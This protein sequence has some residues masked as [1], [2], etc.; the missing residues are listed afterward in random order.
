MSSK[1]IWVILFALAMGYLESAVVVYLRALYYPEGFN[2]PLKEMSETLALTELFREAATLIMIFSV[3]VLVAKYWLHRFAW[4]LMVFAVWDISYYVFLK[5][6]LGW[7]ESL[8]TNDI[9]FLLPGIW[10]GPVIAP[11]INSIS[12]IM[13]AF[14]ILKSSESSKPVFQLSLIVWVLLITGSLLILIAYMEDFAVYAYDSKHSIPSA[15]FS[16]NQIISK[17]SARYVPGSFDWLLFCSGAAMHLLA[18]FLI[19]ITNRK[20]TEKFKSMRL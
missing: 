20:V 13:L 1:M 3:G 5:V 16:W 15:E 7:P 9:L 14:V 12:M 18:I 17:L 6:L 2:F 19:A 4:S 11:V 8:L 10:T